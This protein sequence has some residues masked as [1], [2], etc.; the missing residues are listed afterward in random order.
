MSIEIFK[1]EL[2]YEDLSGMN[3]SKTKTP[4]EVLIE[5]ENT[6]TEEIFEEIQNYLKEGVKRIIFEKFKQV[7]TG[8]EE[9][10]LST[11]F[12]GIDKHYEAKETQDAT[13]EKMG[14]TREYYGLLL[15]R[16]YKKILENK[17][18]REECVDFVKNSQFFLS[19]VKK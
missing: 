19:R 15:H 14:I 11:L 1:D 17:D 18:L 9:K 4:E 5:K 3:A 2:K 7:L 6:N 8:R 10:F 13:A 16:V 12:F